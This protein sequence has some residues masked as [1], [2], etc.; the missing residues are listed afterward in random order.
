[1]LGRTL[2]Y[3]RAIHTR[4]V[5]SILEKPRTTYCI[6]ESVSF[7][8]V[9][10]P[11]INERGQIVGV[12]GFDMSAAEGGDLYVRSGHPLIYQASLFK[13]YIDDP[14][15][16]DHADADKDDAWLGVFTQP[17]TDDMAEYWG[18][19]EEG[20]IVVNTVVPESPA[21]RAGL[22]MGDVIIDANGVTLSAKQDREVL[23]FTKLIRETG[24]DTEITLRY[25]RGGRDRRTDRATREPAKICP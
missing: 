11:V 18:I 4:H 17:L 22:Q 13:K 15:Q 23:G 19:P 9:G 14:P 8:L 16:E 24:A 5:G 20:G 21:F 12:V 1:M 6:D 10:G 25:Y 7:G 2:D 3:D